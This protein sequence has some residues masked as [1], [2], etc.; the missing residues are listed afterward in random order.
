MPN[1]FPHQVSQCLDRPATVTEMSLYYDAATVLT[2]TAQEGS[3]KSRIYGNKLGLKSK[4][5]HIYALISETAKY[6]QFIK[7][8]VDN[9]GLLAQEPKVRKALSQFL[10]SL[11]TDSA[12]GLL[13]I[14]DTTPF[15]ASCPRPFLLEEWSC[16]ALCPS[17]PTSDREKQN[18]AASGI[19]KGQAAEK[20]RYVRRAT[21]SAFD[22]MSSNIPLPAKMDSHQHLKD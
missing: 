13:L 9:A 18:K 20:M 2:A 17:S 7:E 15:I 11:L 22:G 3:L 1:A 19:H 14:V 6:D 8:V 5:A 21:K 10:V 16:S 12:S 4:P